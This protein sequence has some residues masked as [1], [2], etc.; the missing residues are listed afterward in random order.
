MEDPWSSPW[1]TDTPAPPTIDL[2]SEPQRAHF[3]ASPRK[4]SR[5]PSPWGRPV[6]DGEDDW[7]GWNEAGG[8]DSPGWGRSPNLKPLGTAAG[9]LDPWALPGSDEKERDKGADS[10]ISLGDDGRVD[11]HFRVT[12]QNTWEDGQVEV[13]QEERN[14]E[15]EE[16]A[17]AEQAPVEAKQ[18]SKVQELVEMYDGMARIA[19]VD[20]AGSNADNTVEVTA[21]AEA[22]VTADTAG[23][24][25]EDTTEDTTA[26]A[27]ADTTADTVGKSPDVIKDDDEAVQADAAD[28]LT[29]S[30]PSDKD[31]Q[32]GEY[33]TPDLPD[34]SQETTNEEAKTNRTTPTHPPVPYAIDFTHLDTLFPNTPAVRT[35][36]EELPESIVKESFTS[37]SQRKAWYRISRFGSIRK[38][39]DGDDENYVR[40]GWNDSAV[41]KDTL[42]TVRRWM[43]EDS[44]GGRV[45]LGRRLGHGGGSI[46]NWDSEAPPVE[47]GELLAKRK[48]V[49]SRLSEAKEADV[50]PAAK[51]PTH[52]DAPLQNEDDDWGEMV[53]TPMDS[54]FGGSPAAPSVAKP[55]TSD[56]IVPTQ[57]ADPWGGLDMFG[58]GPGTP[59]QPVPSAKDPPLALSTSAPPTKP[60][61]V[62]SSPASSRPSNELAPQSVQEDAAA[63]ILAGLPDLSYMLK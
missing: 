24:T 43:E 45:V 49:A 11:G 13:A 48:P 39:N 20:S 63:A 58:G 5:S 60:I 54:T 33:P 32:H 28:E 2:P 37:V 10:A 53:T 42:T 36:P 38:H 34:D 1:A 4:A 18:P 26:F 19:K 46:F 15:E 31:D 7:G 59:L 56:A 17:T 21:E 62:Q 22:E 12:S 47:I 51:S 61:T 50:A 23:D 8:K 14:H 41:R 57:V 27:A 40:V 25:T 16:S 6:D 9:S 35:T 3:G 44:I 52:V 30:T 29:N 55:I